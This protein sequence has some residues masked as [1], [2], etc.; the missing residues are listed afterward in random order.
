MRK[1]IR[2]FVALFVLF[3]TFVN[4]FLTHTST[5]SAEET[6][7]TYADGEYDV[8]FT[9][10]NGTK[11]EASMADQYF[12]KPAK[13]VVEN[14]ELKVKVEHN[15]F[16]TELKVNNT[17]VNTTSQD[18]G[19]IVAEFP[20]SD[21]ENVVNAEI[22]VIVSAIGY[23]HWY[24]V[25][26][27]FD[28]SNIP[29]AEIPEE[30]EEIIADGNYTIEFQVWKDSTDEPSSLG[31]YLSKP[32]QLVVENQKKYMVVTLSSSQFITAFKTEFN[33]QLVDA[34]IVKEDTENQLRTLKFP[35]EDLTKV[36][37][38][39][40]TMSYGMTHEVRIIPDKNTLTVVSNPSEEE[41]TPGEKEQTPG[42]EE[43]T[44][45]EEETDN[46][47]LKDG[48]YTVD[49]SVLHGTE[50]EPSM[51]DS[52][53]TKPGKL[54]VKDGE[55]VAQVEMQSENIKEL[56]VQSQPVKIVSSNETTQVV[57]FPVKDIFNPVNARI[58]VVVESINYDHWY[59][60]R[61]QFDT[62][63]L[64]IADN[65]TGGQT[66][67]PNNDDE[68]NDSASGNGEDSNKDDSS[69]TTDEDLNYDRN[70]DQDSTSETNTDTNGSVI[71][72]KTGDTAQI[73]L[74]VALMIVSFVIIARK[75]RTRTL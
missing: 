15:P 54:I 19:N 48:E 41:Q 28:G 9:V 4:P 73:M 8:P 49:Y 47:I 23:D 64:P 40:L 13:V 44:P 24:D 20:V 52:Y 34:E 57:E 32:A 67:E 50:N 17:A 60:I 33:G 72:A 6:S 36:V 16:I 69:N 63:D 12:Q 58:H 45:E 18:N 59:D 62:S 22:H 1:T 75:Y 68:N 65:E 61:F 29:S 3:V 35:I 46:G 56:Q 25:R 37:N 5:V 70:G 55:I 27:D 31:N 51:A 21:L 43:Q 42:E 74:Y 30:Q 14:G 39:H 7:R 53:F 66:D 2:I 10:L 26:F 11:D 71:N 38:T